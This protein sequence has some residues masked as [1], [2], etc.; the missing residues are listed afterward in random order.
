[1]VCSDRYN[2]TWTEWR[3]GNRNVWLTVL[4][5]GKSEIKVPA[6]SVSAERL[7]SGSQKVPPVLTWWKGLRELGEISFIRALISFMKAPSS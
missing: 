6:D 4:E 2:I 7:L 5:S 3:K 1:M